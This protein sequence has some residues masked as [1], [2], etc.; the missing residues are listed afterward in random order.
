[1]VWNSVGYGLLT[2][3]LGYWSGSGNITLE[4]LLKAIIY[5]LAVA[6]VYAETTIADIAG[7]K[8]AGATTTGVMLGERI[9]A[10]LGTVMVGLSAITAALLH[11]WIGFIPAAITFVLFMKALY[12]HD[13]IDFVSRAK[14]AFRTAGGVYALNIG[15]HYPI[16]ILM[17]IVV[18]AGMKIYYRTRFGLNYPGLSGD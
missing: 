2:F 1:M 8:T 17:G 10:I 13:K 9:T 4:S 12:E 15:I 5:M 18:Y 6:G 7:D 14:F 16:Y 3:L 11:D